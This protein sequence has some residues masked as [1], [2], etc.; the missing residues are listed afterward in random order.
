[1]ISVAKILTR[2]RVVAAVGIGVA[3]VP[4]V[5][6]VC[7]WGFLNDNAGGITALATVVLAATTFLYVVLVGEQLSRQTRQAETT[8]RARVVAVSMELIQAKAMFAVTG[9]EPTVLRDSAYPYAIA[10]LP[11]FCEKTDTFASV[12]VAY[13]AMA[14]SNA[15]CH[16][17]SASVDEKRDAWQSCKKLVA[18][19]NKHTAKDRK[20]KSIWASVM[21]G[22]K[23]GEDASGEDE[24]QK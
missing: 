10:D 16:S 20:L 11:R 24:D 14:R 19:A 18:L 15:A 6:V 8:S 4:A 17:T 21:G 9:E 13:G 1:M 23:I 22:V 3:V 12:L 2:R 5:L 7:N